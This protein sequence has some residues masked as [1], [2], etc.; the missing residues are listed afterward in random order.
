VKN[1]QTTPIHLYIIFLF[2]IWSLVIAVL[3]NWTIN[4]NALESQEL[5]E[6]QARANFNKDK[7]FRLWMAKHGRIYIPVS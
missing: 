2:V 1:F 3:A 5:A 6:N 4:Q 7:A